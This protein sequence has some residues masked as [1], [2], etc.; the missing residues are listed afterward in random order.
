MRIRA[1]TQAC[2]STQAGGQNGIGDRG[3]SPAGVVVVLAL[4]GVG[5]ILWAKA[6]P[7]LREWPRVI[8]GLLV[9]AGGAML[10]IDLLRLAFGR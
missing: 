7:K 6:P 9:I 8:G 2:Q 5:I 3:P 4:V 1:E 10:V